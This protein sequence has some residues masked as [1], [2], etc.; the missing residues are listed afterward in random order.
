VRCFLAHIGDTLYL[1]ADGPAA[2]RMYLKAGFEQ[3]EPPLTWYW[4]S[5]D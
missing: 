5:K 1:Y 2:I 4:A 3:L